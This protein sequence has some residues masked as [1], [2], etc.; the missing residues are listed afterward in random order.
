[1]Q[2]ITIT[3]E[4]ELADEIDN[5]VKRHGYQSRSEA[6]RDLVRA[7]MAETQQLTHKAAECM[8]SVIYVYDQR[9]RELPK[10]LANAY[11]EHH[12]LSVATVR[13]A[14]DH[15]TCMDV[16]VL[17]GRAAEVKSLAEQIIAERGVRHGRVTIIPAEI[18][19]ARHGHGRRQAHTH[20]HIRVR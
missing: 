17:K 18:E 3:I 12:D 5:L 20:Q 19:S 11:L 10:R 9:K 15:N 2:R 14:L 13:I 6:M 1:M 16:A 7:G 4:D 8:A